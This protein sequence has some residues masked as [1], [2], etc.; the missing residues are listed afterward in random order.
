M[1]RATLTASTLGLALSMTLQDSTAD[2]GSLAALSL[3]PPT[4]SPNTPP[5]GFEDY[6]HLAEISEM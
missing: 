5:V 2:H 4:D 3:S 6:P 1:Q